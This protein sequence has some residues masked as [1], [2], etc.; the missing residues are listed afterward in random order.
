MDD[1]KEAFNKVL[2]EDFVNE[3][4]N[5]LL[6]IAYALAAVI[7]LVVIYI[8]WK[9]IACGKIKK[10]IL[11]LSE[12][13]TDEQATTFASTINKIS[14]IGKFFAKN[15]KGYSG[16]SQ[17]ECRIIF[18]S[19]VLTSSKIGNDNKKAVRDSLMKIGCNG[20]TDIGSM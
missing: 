4:L 18:N 20:L 15:S 13:P 19:T 1:V 12:H 14:P 3:M 8:V 17:S 6:I 11:A 7:L 2:G 10:A 16:I 9:A 5:R